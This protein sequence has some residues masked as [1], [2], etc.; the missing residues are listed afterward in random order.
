LGV[1]LPGRQEGYYDLQAKDIETAV[2]GQYGVQ[3][4]ILFANYD[5]TMQAAQIEMM[6]AQGVDIIAIQPLDPQTCAASLNK[7]KDAGIPVILI[8]DDTTGVLDGLYTASINWDYYTASVRL[9]DWLYE[10]M[11]SGLNMAE[12]TV[13]AGSQMGIDVTQG[14]K[15][16]SE[17]Y[18]FNVLESQPGDYTREQ[19]M[20]LTRNI[21]IK[22]P[23][24]DVIFCHTDYMAL[25]AQ[26]TVEEMG[27][28][29]KVTVVCIGCM[30]EAINS[31]A[32]GKLGAES[33]LDPH[34]GEPVVEIARFITSGR[35][36]ARKN[37]FPLFIID[38]TNAS[39]YP[40][41]GY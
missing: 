23:D 38:K 21:L 16:T 3:A 25:G 26:Q 20:T 30:Q 2:S 11:G 24:I 18:G 32:E 39:S 13:P 5:G 12:I 1:L 14:L 17:K 35:T 7:A 8:G 37:Y 41:F 28:E 4:N 6:I 10:N 15:D 33:V 9:G 22:Y 27:F 40:D 29:G 31:V 19:A 34:I 36:V